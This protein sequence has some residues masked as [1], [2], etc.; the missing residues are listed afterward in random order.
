[1]VTSRDVAKR[2]G[3]S[4]ATVSRVLSGS[5][6]VRPETQRR[7]LVALE[8]LDYRPNSAAR[9]MRTRRSG[10]IGVVVANLTNPFY[11]EVVAALSAELS[12]S[13]MRMMLW[14]SEGFGASAAVDAIQEGVLDGLVF[15]TATTS[16]S[17]G[18]TPLKLALE[19]NAPVVL[20]T[21]GVPG[22]LC[23]QVGGCDF[24]GAREIVDYLVSHG[25]T[26]L[27]L[28]AGPLEASTAADREA[29]FWEAVGR[30]GLDPATIPS[31]RGDFS[32]DG[33][34]QC[35]D[36]L[37]QD[38]SRPTAI[39]CVNDLTA[40]GVIDACRSAGIQVPQDVWVVGYN[41]I[42]IARWKGYDLTTQ[43]QPVAAMAEKA[44]ELL[45]ERV[46]RPALP[47]KTFRFSPE[48]IVRGSTNHAGWTK[49]Q[50]AEGS[51]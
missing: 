10:A 6:A 27:A 13:S 42:A 16:A 44:V 24:E 38:R 8:G 17:A 11:P 49:N 31:V 1:M 33:G 30:H 48:L 32:H 45:L 7:V 40:F 22:L 2:A 28:V 47:P 5:S 19:R 9:S 39:F 25:R 18:S 51:S 15:T 50:R 29:G 35:L 37:M 12:R 20:V 23:D 26:R 46:A 14:D 34:K 41:D 3:V 43:R 4:Q 36:K 21:R